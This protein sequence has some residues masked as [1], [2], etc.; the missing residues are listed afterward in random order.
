[1]LGGSWGD[2]SYVLNLAITAPPSE[3]RSTIGL[4]CALWE[5]SV[6]AR[7]LER[8]IA[9]PEAR[10][11]DVPPMSDETF[12]HTRRLHAYERSPLLARIESESVLPWGARE[13]WVSV[14]A[15]YGDE[16]VP[17]R[18]RLP[19]Q[20]SPPY[21]CV[22]VVS[23]AQML[24]P[25]ERLAG[26]SY[27][28]WQ[29]FLVKS[30][31]ALVEPVLAGTFERHDGRIDQAFFKSSRARDQYLLRWVQDL[32]RTLD[33]IE[34]RSDLDATAAAYLGT[35][36]GA[37]VAPHVLAYEPRFAVALLWAGG[38]AP[39]EAPDTVELKVNLVRRV[40]TPVLLLQGRY[41]YQMPLRYQQAMMELWGAPEEDK[42]HQ[43]FEAS[44]WPYPRGELIRETLDW[45][46]RYLGEVGGAR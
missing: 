18:L 12:E 5:D 16:R 32:G 25:G 36:L 2:P 10:F 21:Q 3:R 34:Q 40:A 29:E 35:S 13:Q 31:R 43:V 24:R 46:D 37:W 1:V 7:V 39:F 14:A 28:P 26:H 42:R 9:I 23:S 17:I 38:F 30:G 15:A 4:R 45:L 20:G 19:A 6:E 41:D 8:P 33:T 22:V 27:E 44:H 11:D